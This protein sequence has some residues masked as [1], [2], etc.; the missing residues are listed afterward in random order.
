M[1]L[2]VKGRLL[3]V[4][5][6]LPLNSHGH[7]SSPMAKPKAAR[8]EDV[9]ATADG[10]GKSLGQ[11]LSSCWSAATRLMLDEREAR[12]TSQVGHFLPP[13][14][15]RPKK[16]FCSLVSRRACLCSSLKHN[17][18]LSR[19]V[20]AL[21]LSDQAARVQGPLILQVLSL[22]KERQSGLSSDNYSCVACSCVLRP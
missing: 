7:C 20:L 15:G 5:A 8:A 19:G 1:L 4:L 11:S 12:R 2:S 9:R 13:S 14:T 16:P 10:S 22:T 6:V 21:L 17:T 3:V 18:M